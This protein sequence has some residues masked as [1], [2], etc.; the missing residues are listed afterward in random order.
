MN[1]FHLTRPFDDPAVRRIHVNP[2]KVER[3]ML[4][5]GKPVASRITYRR[6]IGGTALLSQRYGLFDEAEE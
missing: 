2:Q 6:W 3:D 1:T 4:P 5:S